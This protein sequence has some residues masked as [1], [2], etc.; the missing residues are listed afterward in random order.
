MSLTSKFIVKRYLHKIKFKIRSLRAL[1]CI[2]NL[3]P[4]LKVYFIG[5]EATVSLR[6]SSGNETL[7]TVNKD[8]IHSFIGLVRSLY[9]VWSFYSVENDKIVIK[10]PLGVESFKILDLINNPLIYDWFKAL[11]YLS[12]YRVDIKPLTQNTFLVSFNGMKWVCRRRFPWD[13]YLGPLLSYVHESYEYRNWFSKVLRRGDVF[14]DVGACIGGYSVRACKLG[15]YVIALEPEKDNYSLLEQ[16]MR[17]NNCLNAKLLRLAAGSSKKTMTLYSGNGIN[18]GNP[19]TYSLRPTGT[20]VDEIEVIPLDEILSTFNYIK[21]IKIDVEGFELEVL[22]G[23]TN[24]LKRTHYL[25]IEVSHNKEEVL[26][27]L[28]LLGFKL[29]DSYDNNMFFKNI[30]L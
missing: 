8:V 28:N 23:A 20:P 19:G 26:K 10:T 24:I 15:A 9:N 27:L 1:S 11:S 2:S 30:K 29:I 25:M 5:G 16:N 3:L 6:D 22:K 18:Y 12:K 17:L 7:L 21:L 4:V 14:V 13:I